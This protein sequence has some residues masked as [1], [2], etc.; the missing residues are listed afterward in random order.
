MMMIMFICLRYGCRSVKIC[1]ESRFEAFERGAKVAF[2]R[3][4]S[5]NWM[6]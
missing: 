4:C 6:V 5:N 1:Q 2:A 3:L